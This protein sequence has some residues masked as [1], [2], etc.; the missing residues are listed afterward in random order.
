MIN[1]FVMNN[2]VILKFNRYTGIEIIL[3]ILSN[4]TFFFAILCISFFD[5]SRLDLLLLNSKTLDFYFIV[6]GFSFFIV[7]IDDGSK[8]MAN[9]FG[10]ISDSR[11]FAND[12]NYKIESDSANLILQN[13]INEENISN[14]VSSI[15][16][17]CNK[18]CSFSFGNG[19]FSRI[20]SSALHSKK[21][22][23][24][25]FNFK[26]FFLKYI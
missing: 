23:L 9:Y 21:I 15:F 8:I 17:K 26:N 6:L 25:F 10:F 12:N 13:S 11:S 18:N 2:K 5:N 24:I 16:N 4:M 14:Q 1:V 22:S 3:L 20:W 7:L 19:V